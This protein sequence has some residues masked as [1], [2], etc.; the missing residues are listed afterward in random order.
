MFIAIEAG[1]LLRTFDGGRTWRDR[2]RGGA[3]D[4][5][6]V[7]AHPLAPGRIY[8]AAV[9]GYYESTDAGDSWSSPED[10][11]NHRYLVG[12]ALIQLIPIR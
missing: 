12:I 7:L 6:T 9:D 1:A 11:L 5:H 2:V 3:Y 4:T 8:S 10:G